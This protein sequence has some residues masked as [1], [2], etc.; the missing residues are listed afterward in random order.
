MKTLKKINNNLDIHY[1]TIIKLISEDEEVNQTL[2][3]EFAQ[4][5]VKNNEKIV[6]FDEDDADTVKNSFFGDCYVDSSEDCLK[7]IKQ[8]YLYKIGYEIKVLPLFF[9]SKNKMEVYLILPESIRDKYSKDLLQNDIDKEKYYNFDD[10]VLLSFPSDEIFK[11]HEGKKVIHGRCEKIYPLLDDKQKKGKEDDYGNINYM[12]KDFL[13]SVSVGDTIANVYPAK[14][15]Q[16]GYDVFGNPIQANFD[17]EPTFLPGENVEKQNDFIIAKKDG[18][19]SLKDK[20]INV[21]ELY[22]IDGDVS[23]Q[24]GNIHSATS[25]VVEGKIEENMS[26]EV[27]GDLFVR[28]GIYQPKKLVINGNLVCEKGFFGKPDREYEIFG[29]FYANYIE[30]AKLKIHG[31]LIVG[32]G[33]MNSNIKTSKNVIAIEK[34]GVIISTNI[35]SYNDVIANN[36]GKETSGRCTIDIGHSFAYE[37]AINKLNAYIDKLEKMP[38]SQTKQI[39][40]KIK[41]A[42]KYLHK[43]KRKCFNE[44]ARVITLENFYRDS[45]INHKG[46]HLKIPK[47]LKSVDIVISPDN[48]F[49]VYN[50]KST[51]ISQIKKKVSVLYGVKFYRDKLHLDKVEG[52]TSKK[53]K[54]T[55]RNK[56][57]KKSSQKKESKKKSKK[58]RKK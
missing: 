12:E 21:F 33:L 14:E 54:K 16:D 27:D 19:L 2:I 8:G 36:I 40:L 7:T 20:Y 58:N 11:I 56:S 43:I 26:I 49:L 52:K 41:M 1:D 31:N 44:K 51:S 24:T 47:H 55:K 45:E 25:I 22:K 48:K 15:K 6:K 53:N 39:K 10:S 30:N 4:S 29:D 23:I 17:N 46:L 38:N 35:Q 57:S 13:K 50:L 34:D 9:V 28:D 18:I 37:K 42:Y 3:N 32:S 5:F